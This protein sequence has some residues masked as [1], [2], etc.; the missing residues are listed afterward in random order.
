MHITQPNQSIKTKLFGIVLL[1][2]PP[3][4]STARPPASTAA[5]AYR[6]VLDRP[7]LLHLLAGLEDL[8]KDMDKVMVMTQDRYKKP[9]HK[10]VRTLTTFEV[11]QFLYVSKRQRAELGCMV[12]RVVSELYNKSMLGVS[13]WYENCGSTG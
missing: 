1:Q 13:G 12:D 8:M 9:F 10:N 2:Q 5:D 6:Y 3:E 7:L 4:L 11:F